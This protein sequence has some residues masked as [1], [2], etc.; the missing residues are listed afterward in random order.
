MEDNE[1]VG[2]SLLWQKL[3]QAPA[4]PTRG[5]TL[6]RIAE[7][8][9]D[10][11]D[12]GGLDAVS[13]NKVAEALGFTAMSL[14]RHVKNKDELLLLMLNTVTPVPEELDE[15]SSDW[16]SG[17]ERWCR[18]QWAMLLAHGWIAHLPITGPPITPNQLAW[19]DR[20]LRALDGTGLAERDK[21]GIILLISSY[22]MA[23]AR[24][25]IDLG[26]AATSEAVAS[27]STL[28]D[29]LV[30]PKRLPAL[31]RAVDA[32]AFDYPAETADEHRRLDYAFGLERILD[33]VGVLISRHRGGPQATGMSPSQKGERE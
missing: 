14:Y 10:L 21:A 17:L 1:P 24:M 5:L 8:A 9:I 4:K 18:A 11:A 22:L 33:G 12:T 7:A 25:S 31:R 6:S 13:M 16:R 26:P 19:T 27:Y 23:T 28:L 3:D 20:G 2:V 32:D 15:P 30:D 29:E